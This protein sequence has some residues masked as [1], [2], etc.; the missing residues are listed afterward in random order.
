MDKIKNRIANLLHEHHGASTTQRLCEDYAFLDYLAGAGCVAFFIWFFLLNWRERGGGTFLRWWGKIT[1]G[2]IRLWRVSHFFGA[3]SGLVYLGVVLTFGSR[4]LDFVNREEGMPDHCGA[5]MVVG[6]LFW[7]KGGAVVFVLGAS[8]LVAVLGTVVFLVLGITL[9]FAWNPDLALSQ[10]TQG[11]N[12][13]QT[14]RSGD[15]P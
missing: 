11:Q 15:A 8:F 7:H 2:E 4:L 9:N 5:L 13:P 10:R 1:L 6:A 3:L 14:M 12:G